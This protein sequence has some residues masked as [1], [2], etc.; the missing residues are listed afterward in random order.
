MKKIIKESGL[1]DINALA[2]RYP[3]AKIYFHQDLDGVTTAIAMK[4]YLEDN[5]IDVVDS[6]VIQYGEKEFAV[7]KP[8]ASG[9]VMPVLVDFAHG[10]PMFVIHT[11][12]HDTQV[13]AE[14]DASKSFRQARSN[15]E[16]ISQIISPKELFPS[17]DI[18]LISTVDSADFAKHDLTTKEVVNFL[19]RLDKEKGLARN[20]M[21]LG[22]VT[23]KLLLAFKNKK[24]FLESLVM[25]SEPSLYSILNNIKTWMSENTRETPEKLQ[26][27]AKDYMDSMANHRNVKA[28]DGIIL[29]YG[30]GTLKGTGSYDR[31]TPFRNNPDA[32]FLIIMW[33]LGLVQAS[34]NPFKKDRELKGVNLGE[35]KDEVLNKWKAQLQDKTIP[36]STIKYIAESGMGAESVGFTFKDFD[37]IYGGKIMMM[38]NGEQILD[39]LK[40][41]IDKP[42]SKLTEPEMELLDKIGVNAWDL[43]QANSGGHKCITNIS[44]LNY[45][46]RA[47]RP[48]SGPYKYDPERDDAPYIK[49]VKMIGQEFFKVLKEKIQESKKEN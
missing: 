22:L 10:K 25:D 4:K 16:T 14:K 1:R 29:Q 9:D 32:D 45:L 43:I 3:K 11:D 42:F 18:L 39:S 24:G 40:T 26:R 46:G 21:L 30:M 37:A 23:N 33:P 31:Y 12:H 28:D 44:G 27:N 17:S 8:D 20:K 13:G 7:K 41:I 6:E 15:V 19:F 48:S 34:C 5:G 47:K 35:V 36:L 49:F 38:D 2:K